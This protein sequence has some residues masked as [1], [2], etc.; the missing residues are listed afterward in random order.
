MFIYLI[1]S[2]SEVEGEG[3]LKD[4]EELVI[5]HWQCSQPARRPGPP[6]EA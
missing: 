3:E 1:E 5:I 2:S 4:I 6:P